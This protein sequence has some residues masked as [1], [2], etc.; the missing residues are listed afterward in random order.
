MLSGA[1]SAKV[2]TTYW[3]NHICALVA[4]SDNPFSRA[5]ERG[6]YVSVEGLRGS[7]DIM[8]AAAQLTDA[9]GGLLRLAAFE[10]ARIKE[11]YGWDFGDAPENVASLTA[12]PAPDSRRRLVHEALTADDDLVSAAM[13]AAYHH[14]YGAGELEA[15]DSFYWDGGFK[16]V[17]AGD[18]TGLGDLIGVDRQTAALVENTEFLL[19]GLPAGNVLLY[20]DAGTGKSSSVKALAA[21]YADRGLK[22]VALPKERI[23][24]LGDLLRAVSG[25]G[26]K[27]ILFIDDLSFEEDEHSYKSFKSVI[28]GG[29]NARPD[30]VVICVTSNRRNI[31]KEVWRDRENQ[32]DVH[33]RDNLQEKRSLADRFGLTLF[34]GA[35][36]KEEYLAIVEALAKRAGLEAGGDELKSAALTWAVRSGG[37]SGRTARQFVDYRY[38]REGKR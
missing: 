28:E 16:G 34:Y 27:F 23:G 13:L 15:H 2:E 18:G 14:S 30:N 29:V 6:A 3:R 35:P 10:L 31:I 22:L 25:R 36:D 19:R 5:A 9:D 11:M 37:W 20:G 7:G 26:L 8:A 1:G 33:I 4:A 38:A 24:E 12:S 17:E 21:G 32:D